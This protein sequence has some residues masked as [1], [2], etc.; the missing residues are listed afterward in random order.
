MLCSPYRTWAPCPGTNCE[1]CP[2]EKPPRSLTNKGWLCLGK[3]NLRLAKDWVRIV[4]NCIVGLFGGNIW[5][6][7]A[8]WNNTDPVFRSISNVQYAVRCIQLLPLQTRVH[9][10]WSL[11]HQK[12]SAMVCCNT[13]C[14]L[15]KMA[16]AWRERQYI[17]FTV[18]F[19]K[20]NIGPSWA[21]ILKLQVG[22]PWTKLA[23]IWPTD[24][25]IVILKTI[26]RIL[27]SFFRFWVIAFFP[28]V[29][30]MFFYHLL[31]LL[32]YHKRTN[33]HVKNLSHGFLVRR[34]MKRTRS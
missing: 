16:S 18:C 15:M 25:Q 12:T 14:F 19:L 30:L 32:S 31:H 26:V 7:N 23:E 10:G 22:N 17:I 6:H 27:I 9:S 3:K 8:V 2:R 4:S 5:T 28:Q 13:C 33:A 1:H 24:C 34:V 20:M 29:I 11:F 21:F